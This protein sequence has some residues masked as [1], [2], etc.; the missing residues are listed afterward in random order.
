MMKQ[1]ALLHSELSYI[2]AQMGHTQTLVI[3]DCGLPVPKG[4]K[5]IDLA[6]TAGTPSFESV[7][8]AVLSELCVEKVTVASEIQDQNPQVLKAIEQ[9]TEGLPMEFVPH[10]T[11]KTLTEESVCIVRTGDIRPYS[12]VILQSG[13]FF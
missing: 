11:F 4:V 12:N 1:S 13:V 8:D 7:L 9:R 5:R 10:E 2:I 3:G 6:V